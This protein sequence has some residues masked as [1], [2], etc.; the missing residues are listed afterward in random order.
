M[1]AIL[2]FIYRAFSKHRNDIL[3]IEI[4]LRNQVL[5]NTAGNSCLLYISAA[6]FHLFLMFLEKKNYRKVLLAVPFNVLH[7]IMSFFF[8]IAYNGNTNLE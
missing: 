3:F 1:M 2:N 5:W 4:D 6:C 7:H 8:H